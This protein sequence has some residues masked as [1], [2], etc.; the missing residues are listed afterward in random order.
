M[1]VYK[2]T[3]ENFI[4]DV[5]EKNIEDV[6]S[7]AVK[8]C[9]GKNVGIS[10]YQSWANSL[11]QVESILKDP[12]IPNNAGIA[13]EFSI[14]RTQN[15]I[16]FIITGCNEFGKKIIILIELKQWSQAQLTSKDGIINTRFAHGKKDTLH[17]SYQVW[18]YAS[19]LN[20]FNTAVYSG[21]ILLNPCVYLHNYKDDGV[22]SNVFYKDY[23]QQAPLFFKT[24]KK[25]LRD[26][27]KNHIKLGDTEDILNLVENG[28]IRP[29]KQLAD[30]LKS[31]LKGNKEFILIDNQKEVFEEAKQLEKKARVG[32][33]QVFIVNGG[34]GT[35][36]SVVAINLLVH[37]T[38]IGVVAQ[39]V[40]RNSAPR[41]VYEAKLT[42]AMKKSVFS[43]M[44]QGS[45]SYHNVGENNYDALV[46]DEA[47]RLNYK[48][49]MVG[50]LGENQV[51]EIIHAANFSIFF[52]DEDQR[53][54]LKDIGSQEEI[55]H[56]AEHYGADITIA[57]LTSQ[58][59]CAGSDGYM[60]WLDDVLGIRSTANTKLSQKDYDFRIYDNPNKLRSDII[61]LNSKPV[62][63]RLVAGYCWPWVSKTTLKRWKAMSLDERAN[64]F[65]I[66]FPKFNFAMRWNLVDQGQSWLIHP[67]SINEIG[68]IHT[69]QGL[70]LDYIGVIIGD[71]F[72]IRNGEVVIDPSA[73]PGS[74]KALQTWKAIIKA[75]PELG[76]ERVETVIKNTYRTLMS[77]GLKG[78]YIFCDDPET[79]KYFSQRLSE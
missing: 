41:K 23:I 2:E 60:A 78:C 31:M 49:G 50:H 8:T 70:E 66:T 55:E 28:E 75:D 58:F 54:T 37:Y 63:A 21:D 74:D 38:N 7:I 13:I 12:D 17:P 25:A 20:S 16:D 5:F 71:D 46:V 73:H 27:I 69:C 67:E 48:S 22:I 9:L 76:R 51:K 65:D 62:V 15:R 11:P 72:R 19:L 30:Q 53:V 45:G 24:D 26:H 42:G 68:C 3:K 59:R 6:V 52:L 34:P 14:P 36:K 29:S 77:R 79:L 43:S 47:H 1:I 32:K 4:R 64:T 18:S 61:A 57:E 35:G 44:F 56:W 10:E 40:T 39:Y 33:K